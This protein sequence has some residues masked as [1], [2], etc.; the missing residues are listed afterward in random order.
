MQRVPLKR[1]WL[2]PGHLRPKLYLPHPTL[3]P[4]EVRLRTQAAWDG[5]YSA[6]A[7]RRRT[8]CAKSLKSNLALFIISKLYGQMYAKTGI[9][10]DSA[11][12]SSA[13]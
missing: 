4:D 6:S 7:I 11:R 13:K 3:S 9:A 2:I 12:R 1:Y 10:T 5:F 8:R